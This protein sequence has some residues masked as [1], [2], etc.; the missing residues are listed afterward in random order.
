[1]PVSY[2]LRMGRLG[3]GWDLT[4]KS[5]SVVKGDRS[6][7]GFAVIAAIA[8]LVCVLVFFGVGAG[9]VVVTKANWVAVPFVILALYG[10]VTIGVFCSVALAAC[11]TQALEGKATSVSQGI[12]AARSRLGVILQWAAVQLVVGTLISLLQSALR[13]GAGQ[14]VGAIIG[15]LA[16]FAWTVATFFVIPSIALEGLGPKDALKRSTHVIRSRWGEGLTGAAAIGVIAFFLGFLPGA[17]IIGLGMALAPTSAIL[18]GL[19]ITIGVIVIVVTMLLQT[20]ISTVFRVALYRFA[21]QDAVLGPFDRSELEHAFA[22]RRGGL[23]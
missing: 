8:G 17:I 14:V 11:A 23:A 4:K 10:L 16:N 20:T 9:L 22:S 7:L 1:M 13:Q 5:W 19:L 12:A 15:G 21:T 3:R 18:A 6:L 2:R